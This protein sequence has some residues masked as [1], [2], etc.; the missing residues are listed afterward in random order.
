MNVRPIIVMTVGALRGERRVASERLLAELRPQCHAAGIELFV[1]H[2]YAGKGSLEPW[3]ECMRHAA[4]SDA[5]HV[6]YLPDDAILVPHFVEVLKNVI[7]AKPEA[8]I[9]C[10]SNHPLA[11]EAARRGARWYTT[12]DG[13]VGFAGTM[14]IAWL[15]DYLA[16]RER[17]DLAHYPADASVNLWAI[18]TRVPTYKPLPS[19]VQ[20]DLSLESLDGNE[21]QNDDPSAK[22]LRSSQVWEPH[23]DLRGVDWTAGDVPDIGTTFSR[24]CWDVAFHLPTTQDNIEAMYDARR[25]ASVDATPHVFIAVPAYVPSDL[26]HRVSVK[27]TIADLE[28]HGILVTY[29]ETR[30]DSLVTRGRHCIQHQFLSSP[31]THLLQ[32]DA[33]VECCDHTAVRKMLESGHD[34][35]GGAYPWRDGSGRVVCNPLPSPTADIDPQQCIEVKET[36]TGFLLTSRKAIVKLCAWHPELLYEADLVDIAGAPMWALFDAAIE[37]GPGGRPRY[38]SE[39][40]RFCSLAREAGYPVHIYYPPVFRHWGLSASEGHVLKAWGIPGVERR[41]TP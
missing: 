7:A 30:G 27:R 40:W 19:L 4:A 35:V 2:D 22:T 18:T 34:V 26:A 32:W 37:M 31:A 10:L 13:F 23:A 38:A 15:R 11:P 6:T 20:H 24:Q 39:D 21:W 8:L 25:G 3:L 14:P 41:E 12:A 9:C 16:W 33:D 1:H 29:V 5:T 36:G 28:A 17:H